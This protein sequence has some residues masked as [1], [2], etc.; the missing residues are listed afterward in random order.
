MPATL[1]ASWNSDITPI[2][3]GTI[4]CRFATDTDGTL[5]ADSTN[6]LRCEI[7][8][9]SLQF[10][11]AIDGDVPIILDMEDA[12]G[13]TTGT[14]IRSISLLA[15]SAPAYISMDTSASHAPP[16]SPLHAL[17][18]PERLSRDRHQTPL[19]FSNMQS[20]ANRSQPMRPSPNQRSPLPPPHSHRGIS[21]RQP[22]ISTAPYMHGLGFAGHASMAQSSR[23]ANMIAKFS[24]SASTTPASPSPPMTPRCAKEP[25]SITSTESGMTADGM[26]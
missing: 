23:R 11:V 19:R 15:T 21:P 24:T 17:L 18:T 22:H 14:T 16:I 4:I 2:H 13:L 10:S 25:A 12:L 9:T 20:P 8:Q 6:S 5:F 1:S 7:R 3:T 26:I